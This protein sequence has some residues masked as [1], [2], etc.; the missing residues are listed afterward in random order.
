MR[1]IK[2]PITGRRPPPSGQRH[3]RAHHTDVRYAHMTAPPF[4]HAQQQL[5]ALQAMRPRLSFMVI[6]AA[7]GAASAISPRMCFRGRNPCRVI[8]G[9]V[10]RTRTVPIHATFFTF[11]EVVLPGLVLDF[12]LIGL[13]LLSTGTRLRRNPS[14][15]ASLL[16]LPMVGFPSPR[17]IL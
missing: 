15:L 2:Q 11:F 6:Q 4:G 12:A 3:H 8:R 17:S 16:R 7:T 14:D 10:D 5:L 13:P 9:R 1:N